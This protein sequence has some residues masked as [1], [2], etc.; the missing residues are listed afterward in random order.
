MDL[1]GGS[2]D[3][4]GPS[5]PDWS[6]AIR[7]AS[8]S[9]SVLRY[10]LDSAH[11]A[12]PP[13]LTLPPP[14]PRPSIHPHTH[15]SIHPSVVECLPGAEPH[16]QFHREQRCNRSHWE[17]REKKAHKWPVWLN[18]EEEYRLAFSTHYLSC[19]SFRPSPHCCLHFRSQGHPGPCQ[20]GEL[21][22]MSDISLRHTIPPFLLSLPVL[23]LILPVGFFVESCPLLL[24]QKLHPNSPPPLSR[25]IIANRGN[26]GLQDRLFYSLLKQ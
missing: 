1:G 25:S 4:F 15:P 9:A 12:N 26:R 11:F 24:C 20:V 5:T 18:E 3:G 13:K 23:H 21:S 22:R 19:L 16:G 6:N 17:K 7:G 14:P 8:L 10:H 2:K